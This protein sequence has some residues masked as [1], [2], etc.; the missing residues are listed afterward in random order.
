MLNAVQM[1]AREAK[2]QPR[3]RERTPM[4]HCPRC[5]L[6]IRARTAQMALDY[7][8]RCIVRAR[9]LVVLASSSQRT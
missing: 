2:E 6:S 5:H 9:E 7:C 4:Q 3:E 1:N 8:P